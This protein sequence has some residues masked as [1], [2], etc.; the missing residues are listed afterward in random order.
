MN[1]ML[2][3]LLHV[4]TAYCNCVRETVEERVYESPIGWRE[5]ISIAENLDPTM[6]SI[7]TKK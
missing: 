6:T 1:N 2:Q 4:S 7:L 3:V 5:A